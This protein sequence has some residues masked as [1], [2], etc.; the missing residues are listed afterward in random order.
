MKS[1]PEVK[2]NSEIKT[3]RIR[4]RKEDW[5][6]LIVLYLGAVLFRAIMAVLLRDGPIVVIDEGLYT[7]IA[8]S[9]AF[10]GR[11]AFRRQP[12]LYPYIFY[13]LLLVPVYRL[14]ALCGGDIY[15]WVQVFNAILIC[16]SIFPAWFFAVEY[17]GDLKKGRTV[18]L[19]T[20]LM[21]DMIICAFEMNESVLWPLGLCTLLFA[22]RIL[23]RKEIRWGI[24]T[25]LFT[26]LMYYTKPGAVVTGAALL[27]ML[28][29]FRLKDADVRKSV[30]AGIGATLLTVAF[31]YFVYC[32]IF[33]NDF[34]LIGLYKKQTSDW[35]ASHAVIAVEGFVMML[36]MTGIG[37]A[38]VFM[39][40][41]YLRLK[42]YS[43][44]QRKFILAAT[45]GMLLLIGGTAF[46]VTPYQWSGDYLDIPFFL[47]YSAMYTPAWIVFTLADGP[48]PAP[49]TKKKPAL[50]KSFG[51]SMFIF[52]VLAVAAGLFVTLCGHKTSS[53]SLLAV[54]P[55]I[56]NGTQRSRI[57]GIL[58][59]VLVAVCC[60]IPVRKFKF[61]F[62]ERM[63]KICVGCLTVTLLFAN[64]SAYK[65]NSIHITSGVEEDSLALNRIVGNKTALGVVQKYYDNIYSYWED[66]RLTYPMHQVTCEQMLVSMEQTNGVYEPFVPYD[67]APIVGSQMTPETDLIILS[68]TIGE[69]M[70]IS[71]TASVAKTP[72]GIY[73]LVYLKEGERWLDTGIYGTDVKGLDPGV[74]ADIIVYGGREGIMPVTLKIKA[75][76]PGTEVTVSQGSH[77]ETFVV[78]STDP[79]VFSADFQAGTVRISANNQ[80]NILSYSTR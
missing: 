9:L 43:D 25:G 46:F 72:N 10:D 4:I 55:F 24:L 3:G 23:S 13:S 67:Q 26:G 49:N 57:P 11:I 42:S 5:I 36:I 14:Q 69:R 59:V 17:T 12:V 62:D 15:H 70:E 74:N 68:Q 7:N 29:I 44:D 73:T 60:L 66:A 75:S 16:T 31:V 76:R 34:T 20:A 6:F 18:A 64:V 65:A 35:E 22:W 28:L 2:N 53:E 38:G 27:V 19:L 77:V 63:K 40:L 33:G 78:N 52:M 1:F 54:S 56:E 8:R 21:P 61:A 48:A 58:F 30:F 71:D 41:P 50:G 37:L 32:V 47:R 79:E 80:I 51:A 39:I 45:V